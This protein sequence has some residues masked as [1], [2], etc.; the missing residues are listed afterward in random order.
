MLSVEDDYQG[1]VTL[2]DIGTGKL[3]ATL[4]EHNKAHW[5]PDGRFLVAFCATGW[6]ELPG[7]GRAKGGESHVRIYEVTPIP[8][9]GRLDHPANRLSF[10]PDGKE[11]AALDTVWQVEASVDRPRLRAPSK[12]QRKPTRVFDAVGRLWHLPLDERLK[13]GEP[14]EFR[15][16]GHEAKVYTLPGRPDRGFPGQP[17][18]G[19]ITE[20]ATSPDGK[21]AML[22]WDGYREPDPGE[23]TRTGLGQLECW[24][25]DGPRRVATWA[26]GNGASDF[27]SV[28]YSPDGRSV[29]TG[30]YGGFRL[31][32]AETGKR[33]SPEFPRGRSS[34]RH[35]AFCPDGV[36]IAAGY[37]DGWIA[38]LTRNGE[39]IVER[40]ALEGD[41]TAIAVSPDGKYLVAGADDRTVSVWELPALKRRAHWTA[42]AAKF[43]CVAIAPNSRTLAVGDAKGIVQVLDL[44]AIL[45][46]LAGLGFGPVE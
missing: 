16:V 8:G 44:S 27:M 40:R 23:L 6:V 11:L 18:A 25:L 36:H 3:L 37:D 38:V 34:P 29:V 39:T 19:R 45:S 5:S 33:L 1:D 21:R 15:R 12:A 28:A 14:L 20:I 30:G 4:P 32:D 22:V 10:S 31:W 7:G 13:P 42:S 26:E 24:D 46:E 17:D 35:L 41:I 43:T 2:W 9:R